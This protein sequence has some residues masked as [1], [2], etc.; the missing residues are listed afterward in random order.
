[1]VET[2]LTPEQIAAKKAKEEADTRVYSANMLAL[3]RLKAAMKNPDSFKL[4]EALRMPDGSLC[5]TYRATNSFNAV[6]P[7]YAVVNPAGAIVTSNMDGFAGRWN[8]ACAHKAGDEVTYLL[9][10]DL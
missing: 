8:H 1:M 3:R 4:E 5:L 7:G 10:I 9:S 6:V 2:P